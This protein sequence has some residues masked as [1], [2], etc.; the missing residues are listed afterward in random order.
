MGLKYRISGQI[1]WSGGLSTSK[2]NLLFLFR[3]ELHCVVFLCILITRNDS[4]SRSSPFSYKAAIEM[5][6]TAPFCCDDRIP[7]YLH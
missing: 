5:F 4:F 7:P 3:I 6:G 2:I 1:A